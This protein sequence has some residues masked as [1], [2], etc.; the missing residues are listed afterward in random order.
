VCSQP[1]LATTSRVESSER[2]S[3]R[4]SIYGLCTTAPCTFKIKGSSI[5]AGKDDKLLINGGQL[6]NA[7]DYDVASVNAILWPLRSAGPLIA[8]AISLVTTRTFSGKPGNWVPVSATN[9]IPKL[10]ANAF[11]RNP[12]APGSTHR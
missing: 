2:V 9:L 8:P 5:T 10:A 1:S 6:K 7:S 3:S 11:N 12:D 4:C